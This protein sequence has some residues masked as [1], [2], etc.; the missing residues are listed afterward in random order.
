MTN[1]TSLFPAPSMATIICVK[2]G[3]FDPGDVLAVATMSI[4][5]PQIKLIHSNHPDDIELSDMAIGVGNVLDPDNEQFDPHFENGGIRT[6][7]DGHPYSSFGLIWNYYGDR[8]VG[9]IAQINPS[10]NQDE[11]SSSM[12]SIA[13]FIDNACS[14]HNSL[15]QLY[16]I[17]SVLQDLNPVP[18]S[19]ESAYD[20]AFEQA[21]DVAKLWLIRYIERLASK[22][23]ESV[24]DTKLPN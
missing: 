22:C 2:E 24:S 21:V 15:S 5:E 11:L 23:M 7:E 19:P 6:R 10:I 18:G 17:C 13:K 4:I 9:K 12:T 16:G 20:L 1:F 14:G 3:E 8:V